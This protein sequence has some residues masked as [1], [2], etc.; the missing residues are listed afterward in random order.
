[1]ATASL[2][3][4]SSGESGSAPFVTTT[5]GVDLFCRVWG[6]GKL[7]VFLSG[8]TLNSDM[9]AYQMAPLSRAGLRCVAYDRRG[10][11]RSSDP[12]RGYDYDRLADDLA[13]VLE[14]FDL[15]EVVLVGHSFASGEM[16]RYLSR[17]GSQRVERVVFLAPAA[18]PFLL[19]TADNPDGVD[20]SVFEHWRGL[21]TRD[22][23]GWI[24]DNAG[25]YFGEGVSAGMV[26]WTK[27]MMLQTSLQAA[28]EC[29][30]A[31]TTTDFR[32]ELGAITVP[33][34][35][36]HGD[37]DASAPIDLTGR[38]TAQAIPGA[39]LKVYPGAPHGLYVTHMETL[40]R[41]LLAFAR[42]QVA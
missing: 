14:T 40:N 5:D 22:F 1:M 10:H 42:G 19:K 34:L 17:H 20:E 32:A 6:E 7:M 8:W 16:V 3:S 25:P 23:P 11:G 38:R 15:R 35:V 41:D 28:L 33:T 21:L 30:R 24:D 26:E 18:T 37:H 27:R 39:E 13:A 36:I 12:G 4:V 29:N 31:M 9:W 2:R